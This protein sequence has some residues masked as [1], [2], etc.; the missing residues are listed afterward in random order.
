[1]E[2]Y[3]DG[4]PSMLGSVKGYFERKVKVSDKVQVASYQAAEITQHNKWSHIL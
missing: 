2:V 3:T 1:M 4:A